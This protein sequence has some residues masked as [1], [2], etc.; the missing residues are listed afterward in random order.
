MCGQ[1]KAIRQDLTVQRIRTAFTVHVY[2]THARVALESVDLNEYNQCQTQL[3]E[4]YAAA[5]LADAGHQAE[6]VAYRVLYYLY[7]SYS[8]S[9]DSGQAELLKIL[10]E[11]PAAARDAAPVAHALRVRDALAR[12]NAYAFFR[13]HASA[14]NMGSYLLDRFADAV[15]VDAAMKI[16]RAYRPTVPLGVVANQL[17]F[18]DDV[19]D[20]RAFVSQLGFVFDAHGDCLCR[21]SR[22]EPARLAQD[23]SS[24]L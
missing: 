12:G 22:C 15:R 2:E 1:L 19:Q 9:T 16:L 13:L 4:L 11:T 6:F 5:G 7:L 23:T 24:L 10:A 8:G 14:P 3:R 18:F 17:G 21:E 20:C